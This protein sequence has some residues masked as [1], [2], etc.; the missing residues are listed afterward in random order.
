[1]EI[2]IIIVPSVLK[3][4]HDVKKNTW[5]VY[6]FHSFISLSISFCAV[7]FCLFIL[8]FCLSS[9]SILFIFYDIFEQIVTRCELNAA[10]RPFLSLDTMY[11][12]VSA[13]LSACIA[14]ILKINLFRRSDSVCIFMCQRRATAL[15][16]S[17]LISRK[18]FVCDVWA[19]VSLVIATITLRTFKW[20]AACPGNDSCEQL[21]SP[22]ISNSIFDRTQH[23]ADGVGCQRYLSDR[24]QM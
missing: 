24:I 23:R 16:H 12:R 15:S 5:R 2:G 11:R 10:L 7:A 21:L 1:M 19:L 4:V 20:N 8:A 14:I 13:G 3:V 22:S 17:R 9:C 18:Q 6:D